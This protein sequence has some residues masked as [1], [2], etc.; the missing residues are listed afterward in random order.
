MQYFQGLQ[1]VY[2]NFGGWVMEHTRTVIGTT[3]FL[4]EQWRMGYWNSHG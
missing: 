4:L 1:E 3:T 2:W